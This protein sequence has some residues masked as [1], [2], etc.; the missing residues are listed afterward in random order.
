MVYFVH[1][2]SNQV[3]VQLISAA[4]TAS[5]WVSL[6]TTGL[7]RQRGQTDYYSITALW[8]PELARLR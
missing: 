8:L 1:I 7:D 4:E 5:D 3:K 6:T 2:I